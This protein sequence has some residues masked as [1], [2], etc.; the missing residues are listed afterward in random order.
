MLDYVVD[1][2]AKVAQA[3]LTGE[4]EDNSY[5]HLCP[6]F[7]ITRTIL[8]KITFVRVHENLSPIVVSPRAYP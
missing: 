5:N 2:L 3:S 6:F 7:K 8:L 4:D 1:V